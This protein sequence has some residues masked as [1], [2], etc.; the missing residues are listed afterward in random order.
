MENTVIYTNKE[1]ANEQ[2]LKLKETEKQLIEV[3]DYIASKGF[4]PEKEDIEPAVLYNKFHNIVNK[5]REQEAQK[6]QRIIESFGES[7]ITDGWEQKVNDKTEAFKRELK[8]KSPSCNID[9]E[10]MNYFDFENGVSVKSEYNL[11]YFLDI[12]SVKL[13]TEQEH[14]FYKKHQT[15]CRILNELMNHPDNEYEALDRL[16]YF[17]METKEFEMSIEAYSPGIFQ[18]K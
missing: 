17:N 18:K 3:Y 6:I 5:F 10:Y 2:F 13:K 16:F 8:S 1:K 9:I 4:N 15:A 12:N 11:D 7:A 14:N